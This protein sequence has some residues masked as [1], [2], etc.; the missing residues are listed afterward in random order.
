[1]SRKAILLCAGVLVAGG[2]IAAFAAPHMRGHRMGWYGGN[3]GGGGPRLAERLKGMDADKDGVVSLEEFLNRPDAAFGRLDRTGKGYV[4]ASDLAGQAKEETDYRIMRF[5]KMFD[6]NH[7]GKVT[8]EEFSQQARDRFAMRDL[9]SDGKIGP[10]DRPPGARGKRWGERAKDGKEASEQGKAEEPK[11]ERGGRFTLERLLGRTDSRFAQLDKN[12]DGVI[13]A[14]DLETAA[15]ERLAFTTQRFLKRFDTN[16]DGKVSKDEF[17]RFARKRFAKLDLN[18][19]GKI[20]EQDLPPRM[21][22]RGILK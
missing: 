18:D 2:T 9:N 10:E 1:M 14:Q 11:K 5:L 8:K 20:T 7:D 12:G 21:R 4:D 22:G 15:N 6:A 17:E 16:G 19:D 3:L 13:D